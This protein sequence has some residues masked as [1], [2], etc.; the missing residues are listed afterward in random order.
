MP[1]FR[2]PFFLL[3]L[4]FIPL[5]LLFKWWWRHGAPKKDTLPFPHLEELQGF[6]KSW[7]SNWRG[8]ISWLPSSFRL[9][10]IACIVIALARP[11][12]TNSYERI[13]RDGIDIIIALDISGS[14]AA[15][16]LRPNRLEAAKSTITSFVEQLEEDRSDRL[17]IVVFA[18]RAFVQTP[19]T[20]DYDIIREQM[21]QL[22]LQS[23]SQNLGGTGIGNAIGSALN[24]YDQDLE[25]GS[26]EKD[27]ERIVI[28]LTD[29]ENN[30]GPLDPINAAQLAAQREIEIYTIGIGSE[31]GVPI[32]TYDAL[33]NIRYL[34]NFDG[35]LQL[36]VLDEETLRTISLLTNGQ[37]YQASDEQA[38]QQIFTE[39][40]S[41]QTTEIEVEQISDRR[42]L[43]MY[44]LIAAAILLTLEFILRALLFR[45]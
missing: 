8:K 43:F 22:S 20:F 17:G 18:A 27:R 33:G 25:R 14:M 30:T 40:D 5:L 37:H 42:E 19:L 29:G 7:R 11:Y 34:R 44:P 4:A 36:T 10:A 12:S 39:I 24:S 31:E 1:D 32:P 23:I 2:F 26:V 35:S 45:F 28:L 3:L 41:L 6:A 15:E 16:D 21:E 38:L 13:E 9:L